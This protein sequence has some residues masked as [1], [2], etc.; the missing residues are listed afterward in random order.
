M[1]KKWKLILILAIVA[2]LLFAA[3]AYILVFRTNVTIDY[4]L[5][6]G[7]TALE[8]GRYQSAI[9]HYSAAMKI[10][11]SQPQIPIALANA[12]KGAGN[13]TK[14]EYT[15]VS[16]ITQHPELTDLYVALSRTYVEQEKFLDADLMLT[17]AANETVKAELS[18]MRPSAPTL[19]PESGY[20]STYIS[21][22]ATCP[23]GRIFLTTDGEYPSGEYDLYTEPVQ[24]DGGETTVC[25]LVVDDSGLVSPAVYAGYT[26]A[27]VIEPVTVTDAALDT[28]LRETIG[29]TPEDELIS[30][31]L[32]TIEELT[33][34]G[35]VTDLT[36]LK[37]LTGLKKLKIE[38]IP[39]TDFT[40]VS[41]LP[42]LTELDLSG[43]ILSGSALESI[44]KLPELTSLNLA[45]CA[46][47]DISPLSGLVKLTTLDLSNNVISD[48]SA[49]SELTSL[50][51]LS[52][53][54]NPIPSVSA[55][56]TCTKLETLNI[57]SCGITSLDA[58]TALSEL[59]QLDAADNAITSIAPLADC[60]KLKKLYVSS[61]AV[62]NIAV[63]AD[64]PSLSVFDGSYNEITSIPTF[65][66]SHPLQSINLNYNKVSSV[67]G[68]SNLHS[69]NYVMLDYNNVSDLTP[70]ANC[71]N[72]VQV[73]VWGNSVSSG[74]SALQEHSIIVNYNPN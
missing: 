1:K 54:N 36:Q 60:K 37:Y 10:D 73:D 57:A 22:S 24:L 48:I 74:I 28:I 44:A 69:L 20:Y 25:A 16:A 61:N 33:I 29:K 45:G 39:A 58:L 34:S 55:L 2:A 30:N 18:A 13:Y 68:L 35:T 6:R 26:I 4:Y 47:K 32:W 66:A 56:K 11:D 19:S 72:L 3:G 40:A 50:T 67:K 63:L 43:C 65:E 7:N 15:L 46:L 51:T 9:R 23:A 21:V 8:S 71:Y 14:A 64:L 70:L 49:L 27:G 59:S 31:E 42:M 12:Y 41:S 62:T 52:L 5:S 17:R 53:K 38:S